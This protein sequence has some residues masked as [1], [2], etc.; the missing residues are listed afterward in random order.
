MQKDYKN[1][2]Q[3]EICNGWQ[4]QT[5]GHTYWTWYLGGGEDVLMAF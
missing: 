4:A 1:V 3:E 2:V 5:L